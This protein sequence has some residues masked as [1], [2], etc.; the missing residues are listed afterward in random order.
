M[1]P[2]ARVKVDWVVGWSGKGRLGWRVAR[3]GVVKAGG[4]RVVGEFIVIIPLYVKRAITGYR[5]IV[6]ILQYVKTSSI[7]VTPRYSL[8]WKKHYSLQWKE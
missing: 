8:E 1:I 7:K 5:F 6:I 2:V 3:F 4:R